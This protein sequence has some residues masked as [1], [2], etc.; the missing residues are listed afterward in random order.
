MAAARLTDG[1]QWL[2]FAVN[3]ARLFNGVTI[4]HYF[5]G[6]R[7]ATVPYDLGVV[8]VIVAAFWGFLLTPAARRSLLD[9]GLILAC[10]TMWMAFYVFA[11]PQALR[12]HAE[13]WGLCLIVPGTLFLARGLAAWIERRPRLQ[14]NR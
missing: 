13:R 14:T 9:Y 1:G 10:A 4:Y 6:A 12:P 7:P 5:S 8:I 11:G 2:E 3:N